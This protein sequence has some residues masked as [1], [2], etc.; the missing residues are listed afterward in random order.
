MINIR[1]RKND[2]NQEITEI[3]SKIKTT[4]CNVCN[5]KNKTINKGVHCK[6][7]FSL[8]HGKCYKLKLGDIHDIGKDKWRWECQARTSIK[9]PFTAVEDKEITKNIKNSNFHYSIANVKQ[10]QILISETLN[11]QSF[12]Q[13]FETFWCLPNNLFTTS[14]TMRYYYL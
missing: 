1:R 8:I 4:I 10:L 11:L 13:Y 14:E 5:N 12:S 7:C 6:T 3:K 9:F 2:I